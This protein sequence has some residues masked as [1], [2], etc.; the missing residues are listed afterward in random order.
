MRHIHASISV[1]VLAVLL[2]SAGS[3]GAQQKAAR[4]Q[5]KSAAVK[6]VEAH[7]FLTPTCG[8]CGK[9]V[10]H[11]EAAGFAVKRTVTTELDAVPARQR[12]PSQLRSCHTAVV[13]KYLIEGH[14]PADLIKRLVREKPDVLGI[15][16]PGMPIG[17]P[18]MEGPNARPYS[19]ISFEADGTTDEFARR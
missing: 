5:Q 4:A 12:V 17:S 13:G 6:P 1:A 10:Q 16:V 18:G 8:C 14:V 2:G 9:W 19:I 3:V 11:L 7:V 15:A